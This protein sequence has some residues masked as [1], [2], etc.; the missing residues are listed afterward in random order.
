VNERPRVPELLIGLLA[1]AVVLAVAIPLTAQIVMNGVRD[2]K[3]THDT[4]VVTGSAKQ[5]IDSN[6]ATW[7]LTVSSHERTPAAAARAL[8]AKAAA[9]TAYLTG[10]GL[11]GADVSKPPVDVE[12]SSDRV[13]TGLKK[14]AFRTV[15]A[16][17]VIQSFDV[18]TTKVDTLIRA[19]AGVDK[20][21]LRGV[22][23]SVSSIAYLST[24]LKAAKFAALRL[25]TAD[26]RERAT[27]IAQGL[28]GHLGAVKSVHLGVY[29][30]TPRNST[31]V[32][33]EGIL[34]TSTREKDVNAVVS[35]TFAVEH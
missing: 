29:Q 4:I 9:V 23:V 5:P 31:D 26:A 17:D 21:L 12:Q 14:P 18:Q 6:L 8:R 3:R 11:S 1:L 35:V 32:S 27:T 22:D 19:A 10:A 20:L 2:I 16:W 30:I 15:P 34:D 28:D 24:N 7:T 33:N 25:A 13:P